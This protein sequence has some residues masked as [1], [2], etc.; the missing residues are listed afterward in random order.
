MESITCTRCGGQK[1]ASFCK[2]CNDLEERDA[3][4]RTEA[5]AEALR[6][7]EKQSREWF[8]YVSNDYDHAAPGWA[9]KLAAEQEAERA[10]LAEKGE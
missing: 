5:R 3:R 6:L 2:T 7:A 10:A 4:I 1:F 8:A 9:H